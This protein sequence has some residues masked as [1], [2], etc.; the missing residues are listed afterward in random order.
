MFIEIGQ[1]LN[2][3][4]SELGIDH[5]FGL[6]GDFNLSYLEQIEEDTSLEFIGNCNELNAA[7]AA[8]GY[9][10]SNGVAALVTTYGVGD[11]SA[12]NGIAGAYA[13]NVPVILI[14]GIPPLHA[15]NRGELIHHTLVD[16][17]YDNIMNCMKEFTVAQTRLTP[18]NAAF[19]IDRVLKQ[20]LIS[21]RPVYIQLPSDITHIKIDVDAKPLDKRIPKS[22]PQLLELALNEFCAELY[23]AKR[24][25][26]LIDQTA[27]VYGLG[28]VLAQI[29]EKYN[30]PYACLCTAKNVIDESS[31]LY[32][33]I[34]AGSA[35]QPKTKEII[36]QSDCLIGVGARFSDVGTGF[37]SHQ[38]RKDRYIDL[39]QYDLTIYD[40][41]FAGIEI[42]EF[43]TALLQRLKTREREPK[44]C[45][46]PLVQAPEYSEQDSLTQAALW[47]AMSGFFKANDVIIGEVGTSNSSISGICL[48][49]TA[50]YI[51]QPI[52][53]SIGY[54]LPALL[55]S[56]LAQ[57]KR[58]HILFIGDGSIQLT[59]QEL[60]TIVRQKLKPIIF[61]LNNG[62]YT[63]ERLILGEKSSYNDI[64]NWNYTEVMRVFN[65]ADAYS[66]H[67]VET[68]GQLHTVLDQLES[69]QTLALIEL[70]LPVMDAPAS[71]TK[72]ADVVAQYDYG[73]YSYQQLKPKTADILSPVGTY[74]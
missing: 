52:W 28:K 35:S 40:R 25:A 61:V 11:L 15:V 27:K 32:A 70:K 41:N 57:P 12:I 44:S 5:I 47:R 21:R 65:G 51:A 26:F 56:M 24:P 3:R 1:F 73:H 9:A 36:E 69:S 18:E 22:D 29:A 16:G 60:S 46:A 66:T 14:S 48:P 4:L 55:G 59:V 49:A 23:S 71:L 30:I 31:D 58:R 50:D 67:I 8:D 54:T 74:K 43:L 39:K 17:N 20:C 2:Q 63:I 64:Q 38:I 19:E 68:V 6:P 45:S 7:Y 10:R 34:Y 37:F 42:A 33:G 72:F 13:E 62:G 53:G